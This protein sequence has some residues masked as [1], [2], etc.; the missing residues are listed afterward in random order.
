M[1]NYLLKY[2][3]YKQKYVTLKGGVNGIE[4]DADITTLRINRNCSL[5]VV[6]FGGTEVVSYDNVNDITPKDILERIR[7]DI[8]YTLAYRLIT[9]SGKIIGINQTM[10]RRIIDILETEEYSDTIV[11]DTIVLTLVNSNELST[12]T[13]F[14]LIFNLSLN[15]FNKQISNIKLINLERS[16]FTEKANDF[17]G[18]NFDNIF[19]KENSIIIPEDE[20]G[21]IYPDE[22]D[23]T[24]EINTL[25]TNLSNYAI[26]QETINTILAPLLIEL[27]LSTTESI[28]VKVISNLYTI[29]KPDVPRYDIFK[30]HFRWAIIN[31]IQDKFE[32]YLVS[33]NDNPR[34]ILALV[35][36]VSRLFVFNFFP[37]P[38]LGRISHNIYNECTEQRYVIVLS[39]LTLL[40]K[41]TRNKLTRHAAAGVQLNNNIQLAITDLKTRFNHNN[42][43]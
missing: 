21:T 23:R 12:I 10:N 4:R 31:N 16:D 37:I 34:K 28:W 35:T 22:E 33:I 9:T 14:D 25:S 2:L 29:V 13:D 41:I 8:E 43:N 32:Y 19:Q 17:E 1:Q 20:I 39:C 7:N 40:E 38:V 15:N 42:I 36:L 27:A 26:E 30:N 5:K 11:F 18:N 3:K 6:T 24:V